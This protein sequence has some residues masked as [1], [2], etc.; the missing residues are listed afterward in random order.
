M[1]EISD[2]ALFQ[3]L[4]TDFYNL[5]IE[6]AVISELQVRSN[7]ED[8][9]Q[10]IQDIAKNNPEDTGT[11]VREFKDGL[12][13]TM[14]SQSTPMQYKKHGILL[15]FIGKGITVEDYMSE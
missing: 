8:H 3:A 14:E 10:R 15:L 4:R 6:D 5:F 1:P 7:I 2:V 9:W 13:N 12:R 11:D